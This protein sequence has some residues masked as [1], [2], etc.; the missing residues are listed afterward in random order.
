MPVNPPVVIA[1]AFLAGMLGLLC[2]VTHCVRDGHGPHGGGSAAG[3]QHRR[4]H[5][6]ATAVHGAANPLILDEA[7]QL[8]ELST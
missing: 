6:A 8:L 3:S 5:A 1:C 2:A 7:P 4:Q